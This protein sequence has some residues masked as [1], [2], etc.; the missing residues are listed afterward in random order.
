MSNIISKLPLQIGSVDQL[1]C[2]QCEAFNV[3]Y[4]TL[5]LALGYRVKLATLHHNTIFQR[6]HCDD[7]IPENMDTQPR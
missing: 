6:F 5:T 7:L 3:N 1:I 2:F 4:I